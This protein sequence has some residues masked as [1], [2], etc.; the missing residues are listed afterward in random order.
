M[1]NRQELVINNKAMF[2]HICTFT[3]Y[4]LTITT[5]FISDLVDP[6]PKNPQSHLLSEEMRI[7]VMFLLQVSLIVLFYLLIQQA[8]N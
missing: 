6:P 4:V 3:L 2:M 1:K 5:F 8:A 7:S